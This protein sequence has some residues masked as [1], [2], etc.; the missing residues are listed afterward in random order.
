MMDET[1]YADE[2]SEKEKKNKTKNKELEWV[3]ESHPI[4]GIDLN[5]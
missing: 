3:Q 4:L 5:L 2:Y 1:K